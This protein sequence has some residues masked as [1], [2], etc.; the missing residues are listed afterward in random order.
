M[1]TRRLIAA[2]AATLLPLTLLAAPPILFLADTEDPSTRKVYIVQLKTPSVAEYVAT[3]TPMP[4]STTAVRGTRPRF[5]KTTAAAQN[6]LAKIQDQQQQVLARA[7][8]DVEQVYSYAFGLNGFAAV[9]SPGQAH[10]LRHLPEVQAVW[11]DEIRPL[12]TRH[13]PTFLG[14][15]D[16]DGGLFSDLG[17]DGDGV[18][19]GFID[20][21]VYPE[22][23]ALSDT[24]EASRPR[25]CRSA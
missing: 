19:I 16:S 7:G 22:H 18:V 9:M 4:Q 6:H 23:P 13:S 11:E 25:A 8:S 5:D 12:A 21:G 14:L 3:M 24:Q 20:S 10:K 2:V 1:Y 15:F 17:L